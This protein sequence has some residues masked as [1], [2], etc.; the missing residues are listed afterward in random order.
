MKI[1]LNENQLK[2][3]VNLLTEDDNKENVMFVGDSLSS[4]A[5]STWNYLLEKDHPEWNVT[6]VTKG[7]MKTDWMLNNMLP[8]LKQKKYDKV[9]IYG[10]TNDAF[11]VATNL[12]NAVSNIQKMVDAVDEQGGQAYVFLGY[13]AESVMKDEVLKPTKKS[14]G[15]IL[16]DID[17]MK[18][19]RDRMIQLQN[20]LSSQI[21]NA[22]VIPTVQGDPSWVAGDGIHPGGS[23]HKILKDHV[24]GY[25]TNDKKETTPIKK[26]TD[27]EK[28][29]KYIDFLK[30]YLNLYKQDKNIDKNSVKKDIMLMQIVLFI[31]TKDSSIKFS[32]SFDEKTKE[33]LKKFQQ[34]NGIPVTEY[35]DTETQDVFT[36]KLFPNTKVND[37]KE[38]TTDYTVIENPGVKV[39]G[40]PSNLE[41]EFRNIP[42]VDFEDFKSGVESIGIPLEV[43]IRQL[44]AESTFSPDVMSC[45][46]N[47][48]V[49]AQGIA[50]FMPSTWPSYGGG[51]NPCKVEDS[52]KAYVK[53]MKDLVKLFPG[54]LDLM[55]A[56]YNG[57][58]YKKVLKDAFKNKTPFT[59]LKGKI[60]QESYAYSSRI[61]QP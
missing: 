46:K 54:R 25:I 8:K 42:G 60:P 39:L 27:N 35:F 43:A 12:S 41:S 15:E 1:L 47:S 14:N 23:V 59:E 30:N 29:I 21:N 58:P 56:G 44:Y 51:G 38:T 7:G 31:V 16:C 3:L 49:G 61:L 40:F 28:K 34:G 11:W 48:K 22:I 9:F 5:G 52:L 24:N 13:D 45:K 20:D 32:G 36:K 6:H 53:L 10:G 26:E 50:Q 18:K 37:K 17:C 57:G 55:L 19:G 4:G 2:L 33:V